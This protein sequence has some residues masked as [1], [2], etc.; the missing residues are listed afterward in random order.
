MALKWTPNEPGPIFRS[1][2]TGPKDKA[3]SVES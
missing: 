3:L 2:A 1:I